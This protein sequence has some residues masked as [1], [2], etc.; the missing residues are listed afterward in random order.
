MEYKKVNEYKINKRFQTKYRIAGAFDFKAEIAEFPFDRQ[1]LTIEISLDSKSQNQILQPPINSIVDTEFLINGWNIIGAKSGT[2]SRK[3]FDRV[4]SAL[5][6]KVQVKKINK[7]EWKVARR[8]N[9]AVL[10]SLIPLLVMI[11]LSWY[12]SF[13]DFSKA[14][15]TVQLNTTVFLAGVALYF[16]AEKPNGSKFTL[17]DK[18]LFIFTC[19]WFI[20]IIEFSVLVSEELYKFT[21]LIWQISIPCLIFV[22][23]TN[24]WNKYKNLTKNKE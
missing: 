1:K 8:N 20:N 13:F 4:G 22:L 2:L 10:R 14:I 15:T 6:T 23:L 19:H 18:L 9:V 7:T 16:S 12:S 11:L 3:N 21:H 24:L 17:I 5:Q